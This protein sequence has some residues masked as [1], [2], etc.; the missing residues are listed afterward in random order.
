[1]TL[2]GTMTAP[3]LVTQIIAVMTAGTQSAIKCAI[4]P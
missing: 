2:T 1:M 3:G 4:D